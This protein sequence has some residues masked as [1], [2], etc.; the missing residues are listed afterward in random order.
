MVGDRGYKYSSSIPI[1]IPHSPTPRVVETRTHHEVGGHAVV[2]VRGDGE[3]VDVDGHGGLRRLPI[4]QEGEM[5]GVA[6]EELGE[7]V[8]QLWGVGSW[9][10]E[11]MR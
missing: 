8:V 1:S 11:V 2:E 9:Y 4:P 3:L 5:H 6:L 10:T 7:V